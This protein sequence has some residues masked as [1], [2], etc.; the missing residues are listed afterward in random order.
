LAAN[1]LCPWLLQSVFTANGVTNFRSM[2]LLP[3]LIALGAA[4]VLALAFRPPAKAETSQG[5][6]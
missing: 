4:I 3:C 5:Q 1:S 6:P 2:F